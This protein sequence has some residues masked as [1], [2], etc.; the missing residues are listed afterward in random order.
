MLS[1]ATGRESAQDNSKEPDEMTTLEVG[2]KC[3]V[4]R[5]EMY[6]E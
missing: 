5:Q 3:I 1:V 6:E 2:V 4:K